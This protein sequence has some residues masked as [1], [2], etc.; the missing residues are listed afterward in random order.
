MSKELSTGLASKVYI[1]FPDYNEVEHKNLINIAKQQFQD[2][3]FTGC[4]NVLNYNDK[5][6]QKI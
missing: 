4:V 2:A 6:P 5:F 3:D 1:G